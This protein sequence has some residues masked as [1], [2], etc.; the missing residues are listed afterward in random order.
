MYIYIYIY[1]LIYK[2]S[3]GYGGPAFM[4]QGMAV[5][6]FLAT[7]IRASFATPGVRDAGDDARP[8]QAGPAMTRVF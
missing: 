1:T 3:E 2:V 5:G 6:F 7:A 8:G 4:P